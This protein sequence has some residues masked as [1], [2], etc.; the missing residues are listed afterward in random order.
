MRTQAPLDCPFVVDDA[1]GWDGIPPYLDVNLAITGYHTTSKF[2]WRKRVVL[3]CQAFHEGELVGF[4]LDIRC[5]F[6]WGLRTVANWKQDWFN[7]GENAVF[8]PDGWVQNGAI[9]KSR[10]NETSR[11][12]HFM[13]QHFGVRPAPL[14]KPTNM[15]EISLTAKAFSPTNHDIT[16]S[17]SEIKLAFE[18]LSDTHLS[19]EVFWE[20][21]LR[22]D[23]NIGAIRLEEKDICYRQAQVNCLKLA[24]P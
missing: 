12:V 15:E 17:F 4:D 13:S 24:F 1:D 11:L 16:K 22:I 7:E 9:I 5:V 19:G 14:S 20:A 8:N 6:P 18:A 2:G 21:F 23:P 10:G 3:T